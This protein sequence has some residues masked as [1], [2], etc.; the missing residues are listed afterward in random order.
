MSNDQTPLTVGQF[1]LMLFLT[2]IPVVGFILLL[3][4][5]FGSNSNENKKNYARA[6]LLLSLIG[7]VLAGIF[8]SMLV[9]L[10]GAIYS[11]M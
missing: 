8:S 3:V 11:A 5:A 2:G 4:W 7:I 1:L 10:M 6:T 9:G